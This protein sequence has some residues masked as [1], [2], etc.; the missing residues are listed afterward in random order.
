MSKGRWILRKGRAQA[1]T[2]HNCGLHQDPREQN[3]TARP[4]G[5]EPSTRPDQ[6]GSHRNVDFTLRNEKP[7]K[8]FNQ[9]VAISST[10]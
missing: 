9:G 8:S 7:L 10:F 1:S 3:T 6:L 4:E 2:H 5:K